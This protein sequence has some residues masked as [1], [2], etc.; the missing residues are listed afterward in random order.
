MGE[1]K[2]FSKEDLIEKRTTF[3][4]NNPERT[5]TIWSR[6][7]KLAANFDK[8][9]DLFEIGMFDS[10]IYISARL[11]EMITEK[12][13]TGVTIRPAENLHI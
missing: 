4:K 3:K 6:T 2:I 10:E 11:R 7:I 8:S 5:V 13:I 1:V 12:K 9:L